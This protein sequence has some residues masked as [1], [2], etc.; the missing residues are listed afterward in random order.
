MSAQ[1]RAGT[2]PWC[3]DNQCRQGIRIFQSVNCLASWMEWTYRDCVYTSINI[4]INIHININTHSST[5]IH[6]YIIY[7]IYI[8]ICVVIYNILSR[9][10]GGTGK[11]LVTTN[12]EGVWWKSWWEV[13]CGGLVTG[14]LVKSLGRWPLF[15]ISGNGKE[16][17]PAAKSWWKSYAGSYAVS[18][19]ARRSIADFFGDLSWP[20]P[21]QGDA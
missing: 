1:R 8:I 2:V 7:I 17:T 15:G 6:M 21:L 12:S 19:G 5:Y 10:I 13:L 4:N 20:L 14:V 16:K 18:C 11:V 9:K 3:V